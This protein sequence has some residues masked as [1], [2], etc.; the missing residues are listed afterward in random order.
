MVNT[1]RTNFFTYISHEFKTP[2]TI[3]MAIFED[4][5]QN[6][7]YTIQARDVEIILHNTKRMMFLINQLSEF[8]LIK[9]NHEQICRINGDIVEFSRKIFSLFI[10]LFNR[11]HLKYQFS[12]SHQSFITYFDSDKIEKIISNILGNA[13]KYTIQENGTESA[14]SFDISIDSGHKKIFYRCH[15]SGS[16]ISLEHSG[17]ILQPFSCGFYSQ[18]RKNV[19]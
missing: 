1:H 3:L 10:P 13:V 19:I 12:S 6:S 14:I 8:R 11:K 18:N 15:D 17:N 7:R 5:G 4:I 2:L 16:N 9:T